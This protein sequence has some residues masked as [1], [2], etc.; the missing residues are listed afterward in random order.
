MT[1]AEHNRFLLPAWTVSLLLHVIVVFLAAMFV[2]QVKPVLH[3]ETFKWDVTFVEPATPEAISGISRPVDPP[4]QPPVRAASPRQTEPMPDMT[5]NRVAPQRSAQMVHPKVEQPKPIEQKVDEPPKLEPLQLAAQVQETIEQ[6]AVE[7][8]KAEPITEAKETEP[9]MQNEPVVAQSHS[10]QH[11]TPAEAAEPSIQKA[12]VS[13]PPAV[14]PP[15]AQIQQATRPSPVV[16]PTAPAAPPAAAATPLEAP[17]QTAKAAPIPEG[18]VDHRW[19]G[20]SLWRR[21]AELKRYPTS[22]R[23]NG[24]EGKVV[25][26]AVIRSDG[27]LAE[28]TILKSSG[29]HI[30]DSAALEAVKLACPLHMKQAINKPE[31]VVSLPIVYSLAN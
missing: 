7:A 2:G 22:A 23:L 26:K 8:P 13:P 10:V 11:S 27:Q 25:L 9:V 15:E 30:L 21:V 29:H 20:E 1:S 24:Q 6:K 31:I 14:E 12:P 18:K 3:T 28:V 4:V 19:V 16:E 5:M 17:A